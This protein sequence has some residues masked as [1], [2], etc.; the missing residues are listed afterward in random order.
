VFLV[1][2][3]EGLG[4]GAGRDFV[5]HQAGR[6]VFCL[7]LASGC[8]FESRGNFGQRLAQASGSVK[9]HQ[10]L[11]MSRLRQQRGKEEKR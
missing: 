4:L 10:I 1:G 2:R 8:G 11:R 9:K 5:A 3:G 7:H 6:G